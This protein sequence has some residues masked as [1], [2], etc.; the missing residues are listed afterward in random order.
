MDNHGHHLPPE[1]QTL[2]ST[3]SLVPRSVFKTMPKYNPPQR[4]VS[5]RPHSE[6]ESS[7]CD[8]GSAIEDVADE[9]EDSQVDNGSG[10]ED[11]DSEAESNHANPSSTSIVRPGSSLAAVSP[12][13]KFDQILSHSEEDSSDCDEE[14][15]IEDV[16]D[17]IEDS[18]V[19][20]SGGDEDSDSEAESNHA[21]PSSTSIVRQGA[22]AAVSPVNDD[23]DEQADDEQSDDEHD[24]DDDSEDADFS[25]A[26]A[27][28][29][30]RPSAAALASSA[31][32]TIPF[33]LSA[34]D[35]A[36]AA[37]VA[38]EVEAVLQSSSTS[39]AAS[40]EKPFACGKCSYRCD[41]KWRLNAHDRQ[42]HL[43]RRFVCI[44]C[45]K[46]FTKSSGLEDHMDRE[47]S[48]GE[49][50]H[51]CDQCEDKFTTKQ[52]LRQHK[53]T[54]SNE[55]PHACD[56]CERR[57]KERRELTRHKRKHSGELPFTCEFCE[58]RCARDSQFKQHVLKK[59]KI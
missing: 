43:V 5:V 18:Q 46:R 4:F 27:E 48:N 22:S 25:V 19:D 29:P 3:T 37:A 58:Y 40:T 23:S 56:E 8:E 31:T 54:H 38:A 55:R 32:S 52:G 2:S 28:L 21:D 12:V 14:P 9:I 50:K 36:V 57:F 10:D 13:Q 33:V 15:A 47:H 24:T 16:A 34:E 35:A 51:S 17:K 49:K 6:G 7:D 20:N 1:E 26:E 41:K 59:H 44:P 45:D 53:R 39:S 42:M 11:R 30:S